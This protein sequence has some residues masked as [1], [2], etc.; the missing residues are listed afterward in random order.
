MANFIT[1]VADNYGAAFYYLTKK[2]TAK[3]GASLKASACGATRYQIFL[4]GKCVCEG[5][6]SGPIHKRF[7]DEVT[8]DDRLIDGENEIFVKLLHVERD[9]FLVTAH[10][11]CPLFRFDGTLCEGDKVT[12]IETDESWE[13]LRDDSVKFFYSA[14]VMPTVAPFEEHLGEKKLT[15]LPV[16]VIKG[17]DERSIYGIVENATKKSSEPRPIPA[18]HEGEPILFSKI[19]EGEHFIE[20]DAGE[21]TTAKVNLTV[22]VPKGKTLKITYAECYMI[23]LDTYHGKKFRRDK[24]CT[25]DSVIFGRH[26]IIHGTGEPFAFDPF[27]YR[28]FRFIR[29]ECDGEFELVD[30]AYRPYYYPLSSEGSFECDDKAINK[31]WDIGRSTLLACMHELIVDCPYYEQQQYCMDSALE[32][33]FSMRYSADVRLVRKTIL[34]LAASQIESGMLQANYPSRSR[35]IIPNFS[36]FWIFMLENYV[37]YSADT[38]IL[39]EL[40]GTVDKILSAFDAR[41]DERGLISSKTEYWHFIDWVPEWKNG[42]PIGGYDEPMCVDSF[43]YAAALKSAAKI[44]KERANAHRCTEYLERAEAVLSAARSAFFD[45][46]CGMFKDTQSGENFSRHTAVWAT[47]SG[48]VVGK[49]AT[50]LMEKAMTENI[51]KCSFSFGFYL[52]RALELSGLYSKYAGSLLDGWHKMLEQGCTTWA[53][54]PVDSR[55]ECHGWSAAPTYELSSVVLGVNPTSAG[56][57]TVSF[58]PLIGAFGIT[59]AKGEVPT[60]LGVIIASWSIL[61]DGRATATIK[62]PSDE[63]SATITLSGKKYEISGSREFSVYSP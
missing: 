54:K 22:N 41:M 28:A 34:D 44:F 27:W 39:P 38:A 2:F 3:A 58:K 4:N 51:S 5:P 7:Y 59:S 23:P 56:F 32:T 21:Y 43:M 49:E 60:P 12:R 9:Q 63:M 24:K 37:L 61:E 40:C 46:K 6:C 52:F 33:L 1:A 57:K 20:L 26:D 45:E 10:E 13:I 8:L 35:Q 47:I 42:V 19:A 16:R 25:P 50:A 48:A 14:G 31:M 53:E 36:L 15:K 17:I 29:L 11:E 62:L 18:M 55:S 30:A